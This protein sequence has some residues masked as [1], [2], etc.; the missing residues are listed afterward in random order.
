MKEHYDLGEVVSVDELHG[1]FINRSFVVHL[2]NDDDR[3]KYMMRQYNAETAEGDVQFE[4]ALIT[5]LR[6]GGFSM[7]A[8]VMPK[9]DGDTYAKEPVIVEGG[10]IIRFWAVFEFLKGENRY[11]FMDTDLSEEELASAANTLAGLHDAGRG[12]C[13]PSGASRARPKIMDFLP[14]IRQAYA[15]YAEMAGQTRFD[16]FFLD[17]REDV[18]EKLDHVLVSNADCESLPQLPIHGDYHQGNLKYEGSRVTGVFDFDWSRIDI[19]LF[20]LAQAMV[21]F[22]ACWNGRE[23]GSIDLEKYVSFLRSYSERCEAA[24]PPL[25]LTA[26]EWAKLPPVL[27]MANHF[28]LRC[29]VHYF[30]REEDPDVDGWLGVLDHYC[31]IAHWIEAQENRIAG[32]T[33]SACT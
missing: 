22:C 24:D 20:D 2:R 1:G 7:A 10:S 21:Y 31:G 23:A 30:Y 18:L 12:F 3:C 14:T 19:R 28:A 26:V 4:H 6:K 11:T 15:R 9:K 33:Q 25:G 29:I 16:Q 27:A 8:G 13:S 32:A 17:H 5:Q